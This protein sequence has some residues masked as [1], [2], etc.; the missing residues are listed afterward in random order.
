MIKSLEDISETKKRLQVEIPADIIEKRIQDSLEEVRREAKIPGFRPGKVPISI[1]EK[2][3]GKQVESEIVE[4]LVSE[5]FAE[6]IKEANLT[7]VANPEWENADFKRSQPLTLTF[8]I[9]VLPK[10]EKLE[11]EGIAVH[12]EEIEV[13]D[14]DVENVLMR[15]RAE[16]VRYE[17]VE[18][19]VQDND[20]VTLDY[21]VVED[22]VTKEGDVVK[23]GSDQFPTELYAQLRGKKRGE[24]FEASLTFPEEHPSEFRGR[25]LTF[26]GRI[27]E[28]KG[29][30][31]PELDDEF[32]KNLGYE[33]IGTLRE[34]V[35][36]EVLAAKTKNLRKRQIVEIIEKLVETHEFPVPDSMLDSEISSL[37]ASARG[38][39]ESKGKDDA[40]LREELREEARRNVKASII[41]NT[42]GQKEGVAVSEEDMKAKILEVSQ[43][44]FIPPQNLVQMYIS[45]DGSLEGLRYGVFKEKVAELIHS[46]AK[47]EKGA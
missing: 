9:E 26:R 2:K 16:H 18:R 8:A 38:K 4:K 40:A 7:P 32:A 13:S 47:V 46:K 45:R 22:H 29:L 43:S 41:L 44:T 1:I 10:I 39:D 23:V 11:Y 34:K 12:D 24:E 19:P 36:E 31:V 30:S 15:T 33:G 42:I 20:L 5:Y 27:G 6:S 25:V 17:A 35:K 14:E 37:V 21:E 28:T 3:Y